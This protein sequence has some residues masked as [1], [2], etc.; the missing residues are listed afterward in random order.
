[1]MCDVM[2]CDDVRF[3]VGREERWE[4][5]VNEMNILIIK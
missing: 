4:N 3:Y 1:M 5:E 2:M